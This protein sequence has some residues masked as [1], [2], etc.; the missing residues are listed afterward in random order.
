MRAWTAALV[1]L[2]LLAAVPAYAVGFLTQDELVGRD[3]DS[4]V[5]LPPYTYVTVIQRFGE[6]AVINYRV[7]DLVYE[8]RVSQ[9]DLE[10]VRP[11]EIDAQPSSDREQLAA[12]YRER[13]PFDIY[14]DKQAPAVD[15]KA[16]EA[17]PGP[18]SY[19]LR[20]K[21]RNLTP[22]IVSNIRFE[23]QVYFDHDQPLEGNVLWQLRI[24]STKP[25]EF[26]TVETVRF[27][28]DTIQDESASAATDA[29]DKT[30]AA[31]VKSTPEDGAAEEEE[32]P[33]PPTMRYSV[34]LFVDE[35]FIAQ[36][37]GVVKPVDEESA[38][39]IWEAAYGPRQWL[40]RP[41]GR[42]TQ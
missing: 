24:L 7:G 5:V 30:G 29:K 23:V 6:H 38:E 3:G 20:V 36:R 33:G 22:D 27:S 2:S 32:A 12:F 19:R 1:L 8:L 4:L 16:D 42:Q 40:R 41:R 21:M 31:P 14:I 11:D 26:K 18:P 13:I 28:V 17:A 39:D 35:L 15:G 9:S 34:R 37:S 25:R 10:A